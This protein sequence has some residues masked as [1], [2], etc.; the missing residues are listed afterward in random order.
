MKWLVREY[1]RF[2]YATR[3]TTV[4]AYLRKH[5]FP[6]HFIRF[7]EWAFEAVKEYRQT[8]VAKL[9]SG[10]AEPERASTS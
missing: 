2:D 3:N 9:Q 7:I 6:E 1:G 5:R 10:P 4:L 8:Q